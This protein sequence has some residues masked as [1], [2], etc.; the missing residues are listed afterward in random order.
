M[1]SDKSDLDKPDS[2]HTRRKFLQLAG[3]GAAV[4]AIGGLIRIADTNKRFIRPPGARPEAEFL[5]LCIR[6]D[7]CIIACPYGLLTRVEITESVVGA[8]TPRLTGSCPGCRRCIPECP[9]G[10]LRIYRGY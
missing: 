7:K 3:T 6:C 1:A 8:G 9:T 4:F 2:R 5:S 10:A